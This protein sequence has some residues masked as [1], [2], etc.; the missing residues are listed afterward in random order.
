MIAM[1]YSLVLPAN[2]DMGIVERRIAER[3]HFTDGFSGLAF[4]AYLHAK[5]LDKPSSTDNLKQS[6]TRH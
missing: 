1:Q 3:G 4:K 5:K 6:M 2:Y